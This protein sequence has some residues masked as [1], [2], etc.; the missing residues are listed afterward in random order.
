M[1]PIAI[2]LTIRRIG[3]IGTSF[4]F[5]NKRILFRVITCILITLAE[6]QVDG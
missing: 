5:L 4:I 6:K 1:K 2:K 3:K